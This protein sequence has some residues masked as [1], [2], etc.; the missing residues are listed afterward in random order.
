MDVK[1]LFLATA[2]S[3][4]EVLT[5]GAGSCHRG[6]YE[7]VPTAPRCLRPADVLAIP[8]SQTRDPQSTPGLP[9]RP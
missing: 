3:W 2:S 8:K 7:V 6:A 9:V 5:G 4:P 1:V